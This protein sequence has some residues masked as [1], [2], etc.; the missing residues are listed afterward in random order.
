MRGLLLWWVFFILCPF[1]SVWDWEGSSLGGRKEERKRT[2]QFKNE[3]RGPPQSTS[4]PSTA[5]QSTYFLCTWNLEFE[6]SKRRRRRRRRNVLLMASTLYFL[7]SSKI[8]SSRRLWQYIHLRIRR[9]VISW[10][11]RA[12]PFLFPQQVIDNNPRERE[13]WVCQ[14]HIRSIHKVSLTILYSKPCNCF[15]KTNTN[16]RCFVISNAVLYSLLLTVRNQ[17]TSKEPWMM[18]KMRKNF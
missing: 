8:R 4:R 15:P 9:N 13:T 2:W 14:C 12:F 7:K 17:T 11:H 3:V 18:F 5:D 6:K 1:L 10:C 16:G